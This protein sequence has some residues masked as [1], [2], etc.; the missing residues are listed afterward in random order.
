M[1]FSRLRSFIRDAFYWVAENEE[2]QIDLF[3][4]EVSGQWSK[5][6]T[7]DLKSVRENDKW[8]KLR[9][10]NEKSDGKFFYYFWYKL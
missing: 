4:L 2:K 7:T 9:K 8:S 6:I 5:I 3:K 1:F 10:T